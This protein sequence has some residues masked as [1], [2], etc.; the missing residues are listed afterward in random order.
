MASLQEF[1]LK[2]NLNGLGHNKFELINPKTL[3]VD[4]N[5]RLWIK[6]GAMVAYDGNISFE[7]ESMTEHGVGKAFKKAITGEG[8]SLTKAMG[9]GNL[10]LA[11]KSKI[12]SIIDLANEELV[13]SSSNIL[14]FEDRLNWDIQRIKSLSGFLVSGMFNVHIKGVGSLALISDGEPIALKV[15][16]NNPI[17]TDPQATIAWTGN[18]EPTLKT[19][20]Q[21]KSLFG[22]G[23]G[24]S[25]QMEFTTTTEGYVIIQPSENEVI[26]NN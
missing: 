2:N 4:L 11:E 21:L 8:V 17:Y 3:I 13:V 15:T 26:S 23:S 7:R 5:G 10:I 25:I 9:K 1:F 19:D 24:E 18:V 14:A 16:P 20:I 12:I 6:V 22:R